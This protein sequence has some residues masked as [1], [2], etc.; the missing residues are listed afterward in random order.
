M[1]PALTKA[2]RVFRQ[3][4]DPGISRNVGVAVPYAV[5][6]DQIASGRSTAAGPKDCGLSNVTVGELSRGVISTMCYRKERRGFAW[7]IRGSGT[8]PSRWVKGVDS[9]PGFGAEVGYVAESCDVDC[10]GLIERLLEGGLIDWDNGQMG[11]GAFFPD[12]VGFCRASRGVGLQKG[13]RMRRCRRR[14]WPSV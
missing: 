6:F 13:L 10:T 11:P 7:I 12:A 3:L 1:A 5:P 9:Y 14:Y 2:P 8:Y 4:Y